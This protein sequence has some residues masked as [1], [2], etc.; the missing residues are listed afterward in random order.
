[1]PLYGRQAELYIQGANDEAWTYLGDSIEGIEINE[2]K[3]VATEQFFS[4]SDRIFSLDVDFNPG[5]WDGLH[6]LLHGGPHVDMLLK[7]AFRY[8][9]GPASVLLSVGTTE[10][11]WDPSF[12]VQ[13]NTLP[14][15]RV[16]A[17]RTTTNPRWRADA[18]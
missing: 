8:L 11:E 17:Y 5:Y 18:S 3:Q 9:H 13:V 15:S 4:A 10:P 6:R 12:H 7:A 14:Y 1:M 2:E 16:A